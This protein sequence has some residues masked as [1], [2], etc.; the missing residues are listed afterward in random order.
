[1]KVLGKR[2]LLDKPHMEESKLQ[3]SPELQE[4]FEREQIAKWKKLTVYET[5]SEVTT[6]SKGDVVY[7][8]PMHL[9]SGEII[10]LGEEEKIMIKESDIAL[11]W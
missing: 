1:M 9:Q 11:I 5:G 10:S 2:I 3:L 6:V 7:I 4:E 8:S